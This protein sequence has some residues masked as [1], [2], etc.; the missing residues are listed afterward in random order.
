MYPDFE[1]EYKAIVAAIWRSPERQTR[2]ATT[3]SDF[4]VNFTVH[5]M[6]DGKFPILTGRQIFWKGVVGELAAFLQGPKTI[7]DFKKYGC[8]YWDSW[9]K[10]DGTINVDYGNAW[11]DFNGVDQLQNVVD[12]IKNDPNGR[13][14]IITGWNPANL[15]ALDLPCCHYAYQWY[16]RGD[17]L[18]MKWIQRSADLMVGVPSDIVLAA[19]WNALMAQTCG[20][21]PGRLHFDL[22]DTHI[23][24]SHEEP[25]LEYWRAP[26][27]SLPGWTLDKG[28]TVFNFTPDMFNLVD[29]VHSPKIKFK[30]E[31]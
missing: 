4:N 6:F 18:D 7:E 21:Q 20:L 26:T 25:M 9:A 24:T 11:R 10:S 23:Y 8:N 5:S 14:H 2:N 31:V 13:R 19:V 29:Y 15:A 30:L 1:S 3:R 16:V 12:S 27:H 28:A 22:G 17:Y